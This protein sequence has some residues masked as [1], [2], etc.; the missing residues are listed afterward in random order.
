MRLLRA[1]LGVQLDTS[2]SHPVLSNTLRMWPGPPHQAWP[3]MPSE[4]ACL[5]VSPSSSRRI[6]S[7]LQEVGHPMRECGSL[8]PR[9]SISEC[10][11]RGKSVDGPL[12]S[13]VNVLLKG[14]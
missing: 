12:K 13:R 4:E 5:A 7:S 2:L 11:G 1:V 3:I 6:L 9:S 10:D 14:F 8:N